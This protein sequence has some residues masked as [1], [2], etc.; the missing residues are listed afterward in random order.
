MTHNFNIE[1]RT[2]DWRKASAATDADPD[3]TELEQT[4]PDVV[5]QLGFDPKEE[6]E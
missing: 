3:D 6:G 1:P 5:A 2:V 4:P